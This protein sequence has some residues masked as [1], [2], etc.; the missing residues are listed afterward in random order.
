ME[1]N[2]LLDSAQQVTDTHYDL[3]V[4]LYSTTKTTGDTIGQLFE[5]QLHDIEEP[6]KLNLKVGAATDV[7]MEHDG[8]W[9]NYND[10]LDKLEAAQLVR[11]NNPTQT[12]AYVHT[13]QRINYERAAKQ[14]EEELKR[15]AQKMD[16]AKRNLEEKIAAIEATFPVFNSRFPPEIRQ[17]IWNHVMETP[18]VFHPYRYKADGGSIGVGYWDATE[19]PKNLNIT[20]VC[21]QVRDEAGYQLYRNTTFA[22]TA[23]QTLER[24]L[25]TTSA[26]TLN[27]IRKVDICF[28]HAD[29]FR[30]FGAWQL[31]QDEYH[32]R[33][34]EFTRVV[35]TLQR[36]GLDKLTIRLPQHGL[37]W[38]Y[39][40]G[41][42][43]CFVV[44]KW[45]VK[46]VKHAMGF[47]FDAVLAFE[48]DNLGGTQRA[49]LEAVVLAK[50]TV[51][52]E[53]L[54]DGT[55]TL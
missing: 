28:D 6:I 43:C 55:L 10:Y 40:W 54:S 25:E 13:I 32:L 17:K 19:S 11:W 33:W 30:V 27:T 9:E 20:Q 44:C 14:E 49:E 50:E 35:P 36:M 21:Q 48:V 31:V 1:G 34:R 16:E 22:F 26:K 24:F 51:S 18:D 47:G 38:R 29:F 53:A 7:L 45:I 8:V 41:D 2:P 42:C 15:K 37:L 12:P 46:A 52:Y 5:L 3:Y 39:G 4:S 23:P